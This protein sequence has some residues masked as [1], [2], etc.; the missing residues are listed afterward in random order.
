[1]NDEFYF[2][3]AL[4]AVKQSIRLPM[5][6]AINQLKDKLKEA[7]EARD[8]LEAELYQKKNELLMWVRRWQQLKAKKNRCI[9][10]KKLLAT[11]SDQLLKNE[12]HCEKKI[13]KLKA[14]LSE[15]R[16]VIKL[17]IVT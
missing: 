17:Q 13:L 12:K 11:L 7:E 5:K 14:K 9:S 8:V 6:H 15:A 3:E 4:G 2:E 10:E 16:K 1:M